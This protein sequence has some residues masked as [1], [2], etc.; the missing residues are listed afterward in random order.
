[1][2]FVLF[3]ADNK[4]L[5]NVTFKKSYNMLK[6]QVIAAENILDR[7][8]ALVALREISYTKKKGLLFEIFR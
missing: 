5:K 4:I 1:V 6:A 3:D 8:D 2:A 7:Y